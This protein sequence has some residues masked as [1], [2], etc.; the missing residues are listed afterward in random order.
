MKTDSF[1]IRYTEF[2]ISDKNRNLSN[3]DITI[4]TN[5]KETCK[6]KYEI[7][8]KIIDEFIVL[9]TKTYSFK[10]YDAK[11]NRIQKIIRATHEDH[12]N[13]RMYNKERTVIENRIQ[14]IRKDIVTVNTTK[15]RLNSFG[16]KRFHVK[17]FES[18]PQD[19][20][21]YLFK[22]D[23]KKIN[24][25]SIELVLKLGLDKDLGDKNFFIESLKS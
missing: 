24:N 4:K 10:Y 18:Y 9:L 13:A 12:Y 14:K 6:F 19:N 11:E 23:L 20:D 5:N 22:K 15:K 7:G 17:N 25:A 16:D 8:I 1:I 21:L 2:N 3:L